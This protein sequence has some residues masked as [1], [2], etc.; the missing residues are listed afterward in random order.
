MSR[1]LTDLLVALVERRAPPPARAWLAGVSGTAGAD[2]QA[3]LTA[4]ALVTRRLGTAPVATSPD[5]AAAL[6]AAGVDWPISPWPL[7]AL[8]RAALLAAA[9]ERLPEAD[10]TALVEE[11]YRHGDTRERE[12][13]LRALPLLERPERF[14]PIGVDACRS[15]VQPVFEAIC[16]E[17]PFPARHFPDLHFNQMVLKGLFTEVPLDRVVGLDRRL[18]PDLARMAADYA[19]ERQLAGRSVPADIARLTAPARSD[20]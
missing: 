15:H 3:L 14:V 5:E 6:A 12:A 8:G 18:T 1:P 13:V 20:R 2:R 17:N 9:V 7:D 19:R 10:H 11:C 16:C 4:F